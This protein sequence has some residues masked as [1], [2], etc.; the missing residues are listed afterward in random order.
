MSVS[1]NSASAT[2]AETLLGCRLP[3]SLLLGG[4]TFP[5]CSRTSGL[6]SRFSTIGASINSTVISDAASKLYGF[7]KRDTY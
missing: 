7:W 5:N 2:E 1:A 3:V 4:L 6:D